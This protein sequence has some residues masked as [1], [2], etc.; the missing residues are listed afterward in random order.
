MKSNSKTKEWFTALS[1]WKLLLNPILSNNMEVA[2]LNS[3]LK[4]YWKR[5][6]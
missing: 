2:T 5:G 3:D 4:R 1:M 6:K